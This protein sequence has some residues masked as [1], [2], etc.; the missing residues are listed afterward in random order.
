MSDVCTPATVDSNA[1]LHT[2]YHE[3]LQYHMEN[4]DHENVIAACKMYGYVQCAELV[5]CPG[6]SL[7][8]E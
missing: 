8:D 6:I 2:R 5:S 7:T 1:A 3:I 4:D